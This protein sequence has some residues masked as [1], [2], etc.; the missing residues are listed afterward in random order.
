MIHWQIQSLDDCPDA[1]H[2]SSRLDWLNDEERQRAISFK[3]EK[4]R[5]EWLLGRWTAKR[6]VQSVLRETADQEWPLNQ[7]AIAADA[8]GAPYASIQAQQTEREETGHSDLV[9]VAKA[10]QRLP[11]SL[12]I[13]H[14]HGMA[15]CAIVRESNEH[16]DLRNPIDDSRSADNTSTGARRIGQFTVGADIEA[17]EQRTASFVADFFTPAEQERINAAPAHLRD[18]LA[19]AIWS[20]KEAVLKAL[21]E[22]L[23]IDTRRVTCRVD[24][25]QVAPEEWTPFEVEMDE[26]LRADFPGSW[27]AW[28]RVQNEFTLAIALKER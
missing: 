6:L 21:R 9:S 5:Q 15:F 11:L 7:I 2:S 28:W 16:D 20:A 10:A 1:L 27:S 19:T 23:R 12:S 17:I 26:Q 18:T 3:V 8:D 22:G 25:G 14:S 4:R 24:I 13:S